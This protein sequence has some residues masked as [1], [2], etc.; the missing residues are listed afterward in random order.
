MVRRGCSRQG[1][2]GFALALA[3]GHGARCH[4]AGG[5]AAAAREAFAER[6]EQALVLAP[7]LAESIEQRAHSIDLRRLVQFVRAQ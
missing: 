7:Q 1:P 4:Y 3:I 2:R 6:F 5:A